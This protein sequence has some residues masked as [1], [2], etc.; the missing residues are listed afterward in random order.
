M[1]HP[2]QKKHKKAFV[3]AAVAVEEP[4]KES[5]APR[6]IPRLEPYVKEV[7]YNFNLHALGIDIILIAFS[8][9]VSDQFFAPGGAFDGLKTWQILALYCAV[10]VMLPYFLGYIYVRNSAYFS[11]DIM[12]VQRGVFIIITFMVIVNLI[13]LVLNIEDFE[14]LKNDENSFFALFGMFMI[15]LGP[16]MC[17]VGAMQAEAEFTKSKEDIE[18]FNSEDVAEKGAMFVL[19]MA[20]GFM[21]YFIGFFSKED[22][23]WGV[24]VCMLLG[25]L[26]AV[27]VYGIFLAILTLLS[28][29]GFYKYLVIFSRNLSPFV[30]ITILVFWSGVTLHFMHRDFAS[31]DGKVPLVAVLFSVILSGLI[32]F[33]LIMMFNPPW[34]LSNILIGTASLIWFFYSIAKVTC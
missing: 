24:I 18:K 20:I 11:K 10:L 19:I 17:I 30:I 15:V 33:R 6:E 25:P 4:E 31:A 27:I 13:R 1:G 2:K 3:K 32:P 9:I 16:M 22:S 29:M 5:L 21:I 14:D 26:A 7:F 34:R 8:F 28:W 23:G 12:K